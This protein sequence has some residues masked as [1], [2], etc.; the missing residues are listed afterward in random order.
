MLRNTALL[1]SVEKLHFTKS[2][3]PLCS[4]YHQRILQSFPLCTI[5]RDRGHQTGPS[6]QCWAGWS[7][8]G[9]TSVISCPPAPP[10]PA[11]SSS[12]HG[13]LFVFW[14]GHPDN[15]ETRRLVTMS[16]I[17]QKYSFRKYVREG[18]NKK[19]KKGENS[20]SSWSEKCLNVKN[21]FFFG[22]GT[23]GKNREI[24]PP[25]I[26]GVPTLNSRDT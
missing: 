10:S 22:V 21:F 2:R 7:W 25:L 11:S 26:S 12:G 1:V 15:E 13:S 8:W 9:T 20:H 24:R 5:T 14:H 17:N 18:V 16:S 23:I 19:E 3:I 6:T 4:V